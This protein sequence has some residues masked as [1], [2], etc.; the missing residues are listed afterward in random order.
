MKLE[1]ELSEL[2]EHMFGEE[3]A[4]KVQD[5]VER[6]AQRLWH[7]ERSKPKPKDLKPAG[8]PR[9]TQEERE[10]RELAAR[11]RS[12]FQ[13]RRVFLGEE[14]FNRVL[15]GAY[16]ELESAIER[17]DQTKLLEIEASKPWIPK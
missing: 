12:V 4:R 10:L 6:E 3:P 15:G 13:K 17:G 16:T 14:V 8:R 1:I 7:I 11:L 2:A 9:M 5:V